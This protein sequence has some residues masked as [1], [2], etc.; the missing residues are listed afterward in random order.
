MPK[1]LYETLFA[2]DVTKTAT[3][4][5]GTKNG[6]TQ[7]IEK[8]GGEVLVARPWDETGKL[9]YPIQKQKKAFFFIVYYNFE[10][11]RQ[12]ELE[13][14]L[15]LNE[16]LLRYLTSLVHPK[17]ADAMLDIARNEHGT[18]FAYKGMSDDTQQIGEGI[19]SNDPLSRPPVDM[20]S[21]PPPRSRRP[22]GDD[23]PE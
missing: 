15:R 8:L 20:D 13:Q 7:L 10:S 11:T 19:I 5:E 17:W 4:V 16:N 6:I 1:A 2:L 23:K 12:Q 21:P 18:R 22:R 9:A 14:D 3:D